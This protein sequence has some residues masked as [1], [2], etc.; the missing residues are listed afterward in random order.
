V[1]VVLPPTAQRGHAADLLMC[2][3][4]YRRSIAS[5]A[6]RDARVFDASGAL[7][8]SGDLRAPERVPARVG[9]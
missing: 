8:F 5:L 3:H 1:R 6:S 9:T 7:L 2:G 4:H